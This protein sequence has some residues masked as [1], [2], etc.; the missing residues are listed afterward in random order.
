LSVG[1]WS[2]EPS[3]AE[4][5][6]FRDWRSLRD[7]GLVRQ[8]YDYSCGLAALATLLSG[9]Y[10][11]PVDEESL[12]ERLDLPDPD[13]R[14]S[15][16]SQGVSLALIAELAGEFGLR[17]QGL[18]VPTAALARLRLP[19]I[20]YIEDRG[21]PHFTVVRGVDAS[22]WIQLADSA[23]GNRLLSPAQFR[24]L[25]AT[26]DDTRGRLL[27][28]LPGNAQEGP[29]ARAGGDWFGISRRQ[30]LLEPGGGARH[31]SFQPPTAPAVS[32]P[33]PVAGR[34][35]RPAMPRR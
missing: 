30:P 5:R 15:L 31:S 27:L 19:V 33:A 8:Q 13:A 22:G 4:E 28:V 17:A 20:A 35:W 29:P 2:G 26:E 16:N 3:G 9:Y 18:R 11:L 23:W 21:E 6:T 24:R 1:V 10:G 14:Q 12:L 25:F 34:R 32:G 7:E